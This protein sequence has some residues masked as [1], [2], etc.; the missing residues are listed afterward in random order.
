M[1]QFFPFAETNDSS[2]DGLQTFACW[3]MLGMTKLLSYE[4]EDEDK[5]Q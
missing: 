5:A 2:M 3:P 1:K 4:D